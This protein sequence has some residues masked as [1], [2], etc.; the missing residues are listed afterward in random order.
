VPIAKPSGDPEDNQPFVM[1]DV[2]TE[3]PPIVRQPT[4]DV[5]DDVGD[6]GD[7]NNNDLE[8]QQNQVKKGESADKSMQNEEDGEGETNV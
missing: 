5:L 8:K 4:D 2:S 1:E 3:L 7:V 6:E